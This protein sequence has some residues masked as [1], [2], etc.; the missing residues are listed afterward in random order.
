[1][2]EI[3]IRFSENLPVSLLPFQRSTP[4]R[5]AVFLHQ[6]DEGLHILNWR[7]RQN[8]VTQIEYVTRSC[9]PF[10]QNLS[11]PPLDRIGVG[12]QHAG[13]EVALE[14][15]AIAETS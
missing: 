14:H 4:V 3:E 5:R 8:S 6:P 1:M 9:R 7:I 13:I 10:A 15:E 11:R 2:V 12:K